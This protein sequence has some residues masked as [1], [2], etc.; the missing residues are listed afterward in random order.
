[1][2]VLVHC[3]SGEERAFK[4]LLAEFSG[5]GRDAGT[6]AVEKPLP[7]CN[8]V[9]GAVYAHAEASDS[10]K[11]RWPHQVTIL[12]KKPAQ[13]H[14]LGDDQ[15]KKKPVRLCRPFENV[16]IIPHQTNSNRVW[17][18]DGCYT[19]FFAG[20]CSCRHG[21]YLL[22]YFL[23]IFMHWLVEEPY[24]TAAA[25]FRFPTLGSTTKRITATQTSSIL[26][27]P[28]PPKKNVFTS[29]PF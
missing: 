18:E 1:M 8:E 15:H 7:L 29:T 24:L 19:G 26:D 9:L 20:R 10:K 4:E 11:I 21:L 14:K 6:S 16:V 5:K 22:I 3:G 12:E 25:A 23:F 13:G 17:Q 28:P 27:P 2:P